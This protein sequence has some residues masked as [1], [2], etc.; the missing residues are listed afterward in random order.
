M[1]GQI[2][3]SARDGRWP[4]LERRTLCGL[5]VLQAAVEP[6]GVLGRVRL[7]QAAKLLSCAGV[8]RV[9]VPEGFDC[10][11]PMHRRGL[12]PVDPLPFLQAHADALVVTALRKTGRIPERERVAVRALKAHRGV[13]L[14]AEALCLQVREVCISVN[15]GGEALA[16]N[17]RWEYGMASRPDSG[18]VAAAVRFAPETLD[19]G[20]AVLDLFRPA[21]DTAGVQIALPG[22]K[23]G[24]MEPFPLLA[25][26]WE[27]GKVRKMDLE[28]T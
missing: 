21:I 1:L 14:T 2:V 5:P 28:F 25:A 15:T 13:V 20:G 4:R 23:L 18:D 9:L 19:A 3:F 16:R 26:L 17:L 22:A 6:D 27:G 11:E 8:R 12:V 24:E 7:R 10:W